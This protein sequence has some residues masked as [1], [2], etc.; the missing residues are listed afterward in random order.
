MPETKDKKIIDLAQIK[1]AK[2]FAA[3]HGMTEQ[4]YCA[5]LD[6]LKPE[7]TEV[8]LRDEGDDSNSHFVFPLLHQPSD[9]KDNNWA[10]VF[11]LIENKN[12][13]LLIIEL[14]LLWV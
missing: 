9:D 5:Y 13:A 10:T 8:S 7:Q 14:I 1:A 12:V 3:G 2:K 6:R 4:E 11:C